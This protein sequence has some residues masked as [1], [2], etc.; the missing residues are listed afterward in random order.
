M[1]FEQIK[2]S[3][4]TLDGGMVVPKIDWLTVIFTDCSIN[5][6]LHWIGQD[7]CVDDFFQSL[8]ESS[9]GYDQLFTFRF[10][11]ILIETSSFNYYG[12]SGDVTLFDI[13][14]PKI[15]LE[16]SGTALD[17]LRS[18]GIDFDTYR[19]DVPDLP[20]GAAYHYTRCDWAFDLINYKPAFV[21]NLISFLEANKLP[22]GRIPIA[23]INNRGAVSFKVVTGDQK[24]VY[25]GSAQSDRML[26]C[27][28]KRLQYIDRDTQVYNKPNPYNNPDSW[29]RIE[30]QTRNR[31]AH[32]MCMDSK[33]QF[34]H[35]LKKIFETYCFHDG[36]CSRDRAVVPFWL[37]LFPWNEIESILI[38]NTNFV[39]RREPDDVLYD[40]F[41]KFDLNTY[42]MFKTNFG[43]EALQAA[44]D[45]RMEE[46]NRDNPSA[47]RQRNAFLSKLS[48]LSCASKLPKK[49][50]DGCGIYVI[51]GCLFFS[52]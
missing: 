27:Y 4:I 17:F 5:D 41:I 46:L 28:D 7:N 9:R 6:V 8:Y 2:L 36:T 52:D 44:C 51:N 16:L 39:E 37:D 21:D 30:W 48:V 42:M 43:D 3:D 33:L 20:L 13:T 22:S 10:N 14:V 15:R 34:K 32:N 38:H 50:V 24:T 26:R 1:A 45:R 31:F 11:N 23:S 49:K 25:L 18:Q 19:F 40:R 35:V 12:A 29:L 47:V